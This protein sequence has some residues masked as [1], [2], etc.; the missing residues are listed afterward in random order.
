MAG[1]RLIRFAGLLPALLLLASWLPTPA[2]AAEPLPQPWPR[3]TVAGDLAPI[4]GLLRGGN[5]RLQLGPAAADPAAAMEG[6]VIL[7]LQPDAAAT[8]AITLQARLEAR[9]DPDHPGR[10]LAT[11]KPISLKLPEDRALLSLIPGWP[12]LLTLERGVIGADLELSY[13]GEEGLSVSG[14]L[15]LSEGAGIYATAFF[16]GLEL[17]I[18]FTIAPAGRRADAPL[19]LAATIKLEVAE[20]NPGVALSRVGI[21]AR[22]LAPLGDPGRGE[23]TIDRLETLLLGGEIRAAEPASFSLAERSGRLNLQVSGLDLARLLEAHPVEGLRGSGLVDGL[24]PLRWGPEG[25]GMSAGQL[26][27]RSPGGRLRYESGAAAAMA[28]RNPALKLALDALGDL[29]YN[30]LS[31]ELAYREGGDLHLALRLEGNNP[32]FE[33]GRPILL[34][35]NL[36]ENIPALLAS[37]Q[38]SNRISDTIRQRI[39]EQYR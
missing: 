22:Y 10:L 12:P 2:A 30:A 1:Q 14:T 32:A 39:E 35:L 7:E 8:P 27:A 38:L 17:Q 18:P 20:F 19:K 34:E 37:L 28:Q 36:E 21:E 9:L 33:R 31:A 24:L 15:S 13:S 29:H 3:I 11:L 5:F 23:L 4:T 25:L 16:R 6:L 26:A